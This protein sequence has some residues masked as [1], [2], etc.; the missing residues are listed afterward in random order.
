M[1][2]RPSLWAPDPITSTSTAPA[3]NRTMMARRWAGPAG[4]PDRPSSTASERCGDPGV[5]GGQGEGK[6][7]ELSTVKNRKE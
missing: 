3:E 6:S 5:V 1:W 4:W 2:W 7:E